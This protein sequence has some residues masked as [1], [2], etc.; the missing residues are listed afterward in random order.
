MRLVLWG[1]HHVQ[2]LNQLNEEGKEYVPTYA[3]WSNNKAKSNY[4]SYE[5]ECLTIV[6]VV[7]H[8]M[9]YLYGTKFTL[10]NNHQ[11]IKLLMTNDKLISKLNHWALIL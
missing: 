2:G 1:L 3:S 7:I 4:S 9:P 6:W 11:P 10:Y 5:G 8:L